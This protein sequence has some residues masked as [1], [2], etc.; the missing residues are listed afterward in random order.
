MEKTQHTHRAPVSHQ[1]LVVEKGNL[2][3][4]GSLVE[5]EIN[6][7]PYKVPIGTTILEACRQ[8]NIHIPT[9]CYHEDLCLA[10]VCRICVVEV[11]GMKVLPTSCTFPITNR[12]KV[13]TTSEKVRKAR[14]HILDLLHSELYGECYSCHRSGNCEI[15]TLANEVGVD[16]YDLD[17]LQKEDTKSISQA[18]L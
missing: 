9:L 10:G 7:I 5:V 14:R 8:N 1:P 6:G 12:I 2:G 17:I 16:F 15:Q 18:I 11:E 3:E 4:I 13:R